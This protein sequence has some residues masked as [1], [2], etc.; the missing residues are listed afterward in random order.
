MRGSVV[1]MCCLLAGRCLAG[2]PWAFSESLEEHAIVTRPALPVVGEK[3]EIE[4]SLQCGADAS[5]AVQLLFSVDD[6]LT[7]EVSLPV[8]PKVTTPYVFSYEPA[9]PGWKTVSV[10]ARQGDQSVAVSRAIPVVAHRLY[11]P[12]FGFADKAAKTFALERCRFANM[13][14]SREEG[15]YWR[16]RGV[17]AMRWRAGRWKPK[18]PGDTYGDYLADGLQEALADGVMI[19][20]IGGYDNDL[21]RELPAVSGLRDFCQ[22]DRDFFL[23]LWIPGVPKESLVNLGRNR[24][25]K[26]GIDLLMFEVY[27]NYLATE[28]GAYDPVASLKQRLDV[29]RSQDALYHSVVTIGIKGQEKVYHLIQEELEDQVRTIRRLAP[30][31][32]GLGVYAVVQEGWGAELS[33][34]A[35][36][37]CGKYFVGPVLTVYDS[38]LRLSEP[39]PVRGEAV[40]L[41]T[42]VYNIGGMDSGPVEV[43]FHDGEP[44]RGGR[45]IGVVELGSI[46]ARREGGFPSGAKA[47]VVW[48]ARS[49]GSRE[50]FAEVVA[51]VPGEVVL[52]H[53]A[54]R[55]VQVR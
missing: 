24:Y 32:P 7:G 36:D 13:V 23:A 16:R 45:R 11:F 9:A 55:R 51:Q 18:N 35:D 46:P 27:N 42:M 10:V 17:M 8:E 14:L 20:E 28:L 2:G 38:Q 6:E 22:Q 48:K 52:D 15:A 40:T 41:S 21:L 31:M 53:L 30:E 43:V 37:L 47:E 44:T 49:R 3:A 1:V 5:G 19:D 4:I 50:V 34:F 33:A 29:A 54:R 39:S 26:K 25:R 12:W